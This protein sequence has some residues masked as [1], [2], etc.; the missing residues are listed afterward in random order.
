MRAR[1]IPAPSGDR[2]T[3]PGNTRITHAQGAH[4]PVKI[5]SIERVARVRHIQDVPKEPLPQIAIAGR[6]NV[7]KSSLLNLMLGKKLAPISQTPGKTKTL[8]FFRITRSSC[9]DSSLGD[10]NCDDVL[11]GGDIDPFFLAL[12]DP[13]AYGDAFP[14][15]D[16]LR[17][18]VNLDGSLDGADIDAFFARLGGG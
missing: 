14:D 4:P 10:V 18:D 7:G 12:G 6:S 17:G 1:R 9:D 3:S 5:Q 8:D 2:Q 13:P 11:D 15:C 16:P